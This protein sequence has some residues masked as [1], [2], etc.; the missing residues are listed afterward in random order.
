MLL[1]RAATVPHLPSVHTVRRSVQRG[2]GLSVSVVIALPEP[3]ACSSL[4]PQR[5]GAMQEQLW[6]HSAP[7]HQLLAHYPRHVVK[8]RRQT[9]AEGAW[10]EE[11]ASRIEPCRRL[12]IKGSIW[13]KSS[14]SATSFCNS[15]YSSIFVEECS[16]ASRSRVT[17]CYQERQM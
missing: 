4:A 15:S 9:L 2:Q 8:W 12:L 10:E 13:Y 3:V 1:M 17:S 6:V 11:D 16:E 14:C 7:W 5:L